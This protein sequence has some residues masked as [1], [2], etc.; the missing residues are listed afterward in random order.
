VRFNFPGS[1][2]YRP[3]AW[4]EWFQ[5]FDTHECAF[6]YD[7]DGA[8]PPSNRYRIVKAAAWKDFLR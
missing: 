5:N 2:T 8:G 1:G 4:D 6:V 7:N 3:I